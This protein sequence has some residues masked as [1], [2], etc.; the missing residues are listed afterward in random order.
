VRTLFWHGLAGAAAQRQDLSVLQANFRNTR[1]VT[2]LANTVLKIKHARFGSIDRESNFLVRPATSDEGSVR[3]M[4]AKDSLLRDEDKAA[5]R[6]GLHTPL[7][8]SVHEAKGLEYPHVILY[9]RARD[10]AD[11]SCGT[12]APPGRA[13]HDGHA[14]LQPGGAGGQPRP[15]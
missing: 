13:A 10:K 5:V 6:Q 14:R 4:P 15:R 8:F 11:K 2:Q 9:R 7:L 12:A 1:A 3:L